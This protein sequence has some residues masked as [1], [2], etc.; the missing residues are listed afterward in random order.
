YDNIY[1]A[2]ALKAGALLISDEGQAEAA[3]RVGAEVHSIE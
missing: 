2:Q 3:K 1:V